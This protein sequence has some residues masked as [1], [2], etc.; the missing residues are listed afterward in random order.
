L[1]FEDQIL[2]LNVH[3]LLM[4]TNNLNLDP[5]FADLY[6]KCRDLLDVPAG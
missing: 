6:D 5:M 1:L 4:T 3:R 2:R